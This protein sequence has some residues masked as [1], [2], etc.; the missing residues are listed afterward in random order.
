MHLGHIGLEVLRH[1]HRQGLDVQLVRHLRE[2]AAFLD[3]GGLTVERQRHGRVDRLVE[4]DLLQVDVRDD[5][6]QLVG[7]E[8][9]EDARV[10]VAAL[11]DDIEHGVQAAARRQCSAQVALR[12]R[13]RDGPLAPVEHT[14]N[15]PA[16][17]QAAGFRRAED[18]PV[19]DHEFDTLAGH[20]GAV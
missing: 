16:A 20:D 7:L 14:R 2:H 17:T 4:A 12:D 3:A 1:L 5:T 6:A 13:D 15:E 19:L 8:L 10:R 18:P 9:L 11:D